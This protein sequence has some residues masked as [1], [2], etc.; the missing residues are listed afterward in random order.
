[1]YT[2]AKLA[3]VSTPATFCFGDVP[4]LG[5]SGNHVTCLYMRRVNVCLYMCHK[6][7]SASVYARQR[8]AADHNSAIVGWEL[9]W[10]PRPDQG[11]VGAGAVLDAVERLGGWFCCSVV[12]GS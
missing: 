4:S 2:N 10:H 6:K 12:F 11:L 3:I 1:M 8:S 7:S 5:E 9:M